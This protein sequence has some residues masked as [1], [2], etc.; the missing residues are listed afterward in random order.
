MKLR[1]TWIFWILVSLL[2][3]SAVDVTAQQWRHRH[4][5]RGMGRQGPGEDHDTIHFLLDNNTKIRRE[6]KMLEDGV[7]TLT[8]SSD[9]EIAGKIRE[10]VQ[11][12]ERRLTEGSPIHQRDPLFA[13]IFDHSDQIKLSIEPTEKGV[14][15]IE[16]GQDPEVVRLIQAHAR[17]V[18]AFLENG[19]SEA[20]KNHSVEEMLGP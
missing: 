6:V 19:H 14:R 3:L 4:G 1:A 13:E 8:E 15:V 20:R 11:A 18:S 10:H 9:P 5:N 16:T 7:E 12:M 17:V 2:A